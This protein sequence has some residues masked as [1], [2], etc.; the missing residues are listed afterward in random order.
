MLTLSSITV[1]SLEQKGPR[2]GKLRFKVIKGLDQ[3][4]LGMQTGDINVLI[5]LRRT[6]DI[7]NL[8]A[9]G[10]TITSAPSYDMAYLVF[11]VRP[12]RDYLPPPCQCNIEAAM[13]LSDVNFRHACFHAYDQEEICVSIYGYTVT[14]IQSLVPPAQGAWLNPIVSKHAYNLGD[15]TATTEYPEDHSSCGILRYGGYAYSATL[16]NWVTPYD[17]DEDGTSGTNHPSRPLEIL[18][19]DDFVPEIVVTTPCICCY[20]SEWRHGQRWVE[21]LQEIGL[22]SIDLDRSEAS[23][24]IRKYDPLYFGD[25][26]IFWWSQRLERLPTHVYGMC[27]SS[28]DTGMHLGVFT[29][30]IAG[31]NNSELDQKVETVKFSLNDTERRMACQ[32][33]QYLMFDD[34]KPQALAYMP[35]YS[36]VHF[37]AFDPNLRGI[38][39]SPGYGSDNI[40]THLNMHWEPGFERI[41]DDDTVI[42]WGLGGEPESLNPLN[43][44]ST[45]AWQIMGSIMDG[46]TAINPYTHEDLPWLGW[47]WT[48]EA[49]VNITVTLDSDWYLGERVLRT[50]A[51]ETYDIVNG[52]IVT[53]WLNDTVNWQCGN[54]FNASDAEF[55]WEFLR[56]NQ[57]PKHASLWSHIVDAQVTDPYTVKVYLNVTSQSSLH[58]LANTAAFLPPPVWKSLD[59]KPLDEI[60]DFNPSTNTTK[61][62]GAGPRFGTP[63]CPTQLYGTGPF[64]FE[65]YN[66]TEMV[67]NLHADPDHFRTKAGIHNSLVELFHR[68]GDVDREG[69]IGILDLSKQGLAYFTWPPNPLY[70]VDADV[71]SDGIVD[72]R[73]I[74]LTGQHFGEKR[75]YP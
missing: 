43:A 68:I 7:D 33:A 37:N 12:D 56:N 26:D 46:L 66:S 70:D 34:T 41:E 71:N 42:V 39:N 63:E 35:M 28:Q 13:V 48:I 61:P 31:V 53:F 30:N 67:A 17:I 52:M 51:G 22:K 15:P 29:P 65:S 73:D 40:W 75:E 25:F 50:S 47:N 6:G 32:E 21:K 2:I 69:E 19:S 36:R 18:D 45:Y 23:W 3:Q 5:D 54:P 20:P 55:N 49:P 24:E 14:P 62:K 64:V 74:A 4:V 9:D 16:Q 11:N 8:Y 57:I 60:L 10:F 44:T 38:V 27:H 72:I 59:G 58:D 1:S